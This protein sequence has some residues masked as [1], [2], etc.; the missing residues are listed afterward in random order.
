MRLSVQTIAARLSDRFRLLVTGDQTVLPRQRTLRALIDWSY[1][2]LTEAERML[3][4]RL[5]V[6]A[7]GWT[8]EA[9]E[10][11]CADGDL[12]QDDIL[13][14]LTQPGREIAS[15]NAR[16][17][18][19]ATGCWTRCGT[20]RRRRWPRAAM[21]SPCAARHL[22]FYLALAERA[23]PELAGADQGEWLSRLDLERENLFRP[24]RGATSSQHWRSLCL[25]LAHALRPYW[26]NRGLADAGTSGELEVLACPGMKKRHEARCRA[27]FGAGQMRF[28]MGRDAEATT[29]LSESLAIARED[30]D[31]GAVAR[32]L[33][34][35]GMACLAS[36]RLWLPRGALGRSGRAGTSN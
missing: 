24:M 32:I 25:R 36:W 6:F 5:S 30:A 34:P 26:I 14:L 18:E 27:L 11:V 35:L 23:R 20:T 21:K 8:L 17:V 16:S 12:R 3:F 33:Q 15:G 31:A 29:Y 10:A 19:S 9:A 2:L 28:F 1:D 13:D 4:Q 7:G 22:D